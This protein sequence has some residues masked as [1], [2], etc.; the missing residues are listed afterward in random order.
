MRTNPLTC[1]AKG[2]HRYPGPGT[3]RARMAAGPQR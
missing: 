2:F 3:S 1:S